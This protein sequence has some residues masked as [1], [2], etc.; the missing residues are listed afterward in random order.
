MVTHLSINPSAGCL[1]SVIFPF[2][3]TTFIAGNACLCCALVEAFMLGILLSLCGKKLVHCSP[4]L[5]VA[6]ICTINASM[7]VKA[8][9]V[10]GHFT[11]VKQPALRL[12]LRWVT[13]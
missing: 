5:E 1:T 11:E 3:L 10:N 6:I 12:I 7:N 8:V 2:T 9:R 13:I 4:I